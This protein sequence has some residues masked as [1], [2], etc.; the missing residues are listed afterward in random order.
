MSTSDEDALAHAHASVMVRR[1]DLARLLS[2]LEGQYINLA[3]MG[4]KFGETYDRCQALLG[5]KPRKAVRS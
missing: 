3:D 1:D 5:F 4:Q 2:V